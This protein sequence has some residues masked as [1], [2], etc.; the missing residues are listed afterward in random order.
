MDKIVMIYL[1]NLDEFVLDM[2]AKLFSTSLDT[3]AKANFTR[4][5]NKSAHRSQALVYEQGFSSKS[6]RRNKVLKVGDDDNGD[7]L[8]DDEVAE[9]EEEEEEYDDGDFD[10]DALRKLFKSSSKKKTLIKGIEKI[11]FHYYWGW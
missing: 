8:I 1:K 3:K 9:E 6:K 5:Y 2:K 11:N 7:N 4:E 10:E